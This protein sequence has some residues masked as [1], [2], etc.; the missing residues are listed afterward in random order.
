VLRASD[1]ANIGTFSTS[2]FKGATFP[3]G[4]AFDGAN[5]WVTVVGMNS[6]AKL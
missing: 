6:V 3:G 1:G 5:V 2:T 4:I